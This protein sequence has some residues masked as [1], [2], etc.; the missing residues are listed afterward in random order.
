MNRKLPPFVKA[1]S[2]I[3]FKQPGRE[4]T[5]LRIVLLPFLLF[6]AGLILLL[7]LFQLT[8]VKGSY[9]R[10]IAENN[11]LREVSLEGSRGTIY[12]RKGNKMAF[13]IKENSKKESDPDLYHRLY[14]DGE[15]FAHLIGYRKIA[16][17]EDIKNDGCKQSLKL[18]DKVG[19]KGIEALFECHLRPKK[20]KK[21]VEVNAQGKIIKTVAM[22][23]PQSGKPVKLSIDEDLQKKIHDIIINN[24]I[25]TSV[26]IKLSEKKLAVVA[27]KPSTGEVLA[28]YSYPT[29]DPQVFEDGSNKEKSAYL[30]DKTQPLFNRALLGTYPPGS[31]FK[32]I[33]AAG[34][35]QENA[36]KKDDIFIDEGFIKAGLST[37]NNWYYTQYGRTEG[38]VNMVKALRRSTDTYFYKAGEKLTPEK[39]KVWAERFGLGKN[40]GIALESQTGVVPSDF[41]KRET[42]GERWY[43]GDTYNLSIGQ[44]YLLTTPLHIARATGVFANGGKLCTPQILK[45]D[46]SENKDLFNGSAINC[47]EM[48]LSSDVVETV[49]EGM[50]GACSS[51]GTGWPFFNFGIAVEPQSEDA[52]SSGQMKRVE[53]GCKTGT[54]ESHAKSKI[55]HAWFTVFAPFEKPEIV[56][57]VMVEEAGEGSNVAAP[58]AKEVLKW[59]LER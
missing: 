17:K 30:T 51:G 1:E 46:A 3:N 21:L 23:P 34:A 13:S 37:F 42:I 44:G 24:A 56:L 19:V 31:V 53:V 25:T 12:D 14:P 47:K 18:N 26:D 59:Y 16:S 33:L 52:S 57:T 22:Y 15:A 48:Q 43:L 6:C 32:P 7:R 35:L 10:F 9:Y 45:V 2:G 41:W 40:T 54:A 5:G 8:I 20:G 36:I 28:L 27:M 4:F 49:R 29:F 58:I 39:I 38:E 50:K 55:P 11:R